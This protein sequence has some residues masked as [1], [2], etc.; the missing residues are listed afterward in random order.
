MGIHA[1]YTIGVLTT[2][3]YPDIEIRDIAAEIRQDAG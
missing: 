1:L 3:K 2:M